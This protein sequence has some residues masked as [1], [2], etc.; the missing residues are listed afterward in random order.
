MSTPTETTF[1]VTQPGSGNHVGNWPIHDDQQVQD[2]VSRARAAA[3]PWAALSFRERRHCLDAFR[4]ALAHRSGELADRIHAETG[5][6]RADAMLEIVLALS[7]V[8]WVGKHAGKVL[9]RRRVAPTLMA[10]YLAGSIEYRPFGVV[11]VI[12]PWNFPV[13]TPL[14]AIVSALAA[15]NTVVFKPSELTPG[16]GA[17][18]VEVFAEATGQD[19]VLLLV[20]GRGET[21]AALA[22]SG[23]DKVAFTG[24]TATAKKVMAVCAETLT[25]MVAECGGK[26]ALIVD[27]DAD[28]A[29]AAE[30]AA[31]GSLMNAGQAC[32]GTER[33]YVHEAVYDEFLAAFQA[34]VAGVEAGIAPGADIG[35]LT[36]PTQVDVVRR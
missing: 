20:T 3:G 34:Q 26:D 30:G 31:W 19:D 12:G 11:G 5:K 27:A 15:G 32:I 28:V 35:P 1:D 24:S 22:R 2:M 6:P 13:F 18:L 14:G 36:L 4:A 33:I 9:R 8:A 10:P 17:A 25:P 16:V 7:H 29:A 23:V 21:G